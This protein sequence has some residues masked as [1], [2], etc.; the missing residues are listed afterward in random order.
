VASLAPPTAL[1]GFNEV[2]IPKATGRSVTGRATVGPS[3][4]SFLSVI[5]SALPTGVHPNGLG[6]RAA[7]RADAAG[8]REYVHV[9]TG[10]SAQE[11]PGA[12]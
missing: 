6:T 7:C 8:R 4:Q 10:T 5:Q 9:A 1:I 3:R 11:Q 12:V 2:S